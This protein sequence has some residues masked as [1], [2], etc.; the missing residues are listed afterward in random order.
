MDRSDGNREELKKK[1]KREQ[2][3]ANKCMAGKERESCG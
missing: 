2:V 3:L 1:N